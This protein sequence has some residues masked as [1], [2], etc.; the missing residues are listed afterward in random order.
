MMSTAWETAP[1]VALKDCSKGIEGKGSI[2]VILEKEE[3]CSPAHTFGRKSLLASRKLQCWSQETTI[4]MKNF[5]P[6]LNMRGDINWAHKLHP[7]NI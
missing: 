3:V 5:S 7:E 1:Q 6:F 2:Y 4:T